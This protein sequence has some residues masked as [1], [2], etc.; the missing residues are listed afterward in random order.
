MFDKKNASASRT[1]SQNFG[2]LLKQS[3]GYRNM[4]DEKGVN[5]DLLRQA[6]ESARGTDKGGLGYT[7]PGLVGGLKEG[8]DGYMGSMTTPL[9]G[10]LGNVGLSGSAGST[11]ASAV[12]NPILAQA[13]LFGNIFGSSLGGSRAAAQGEADN[14]ALNAAIANLRSNIDTK[15]N[16]TGLKNQLSVTKNNERDAELFKLLGMMD[17]TNL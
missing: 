1:V 7:D 11:A 5:K 10:L 13:Q 17:T 12:A 16:T 2:D 9:E 4:Y 3:G 8:L 14:N 6:S 15:V